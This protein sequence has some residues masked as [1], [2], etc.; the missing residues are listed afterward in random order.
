[1]PTPTGPG[2]R[3]LWSYPVSVD[4]RGLDGNGR[5][6]VVVDHYLFVG[7]AVLEPFGREVAKRRVTTA[8]VVKALDELEDLEPR[9]VAALEG[10][11]VKELGLERREEALGDRVVE[12]V[13]AAADRLQDP[14]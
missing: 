13:A 12:G 3:G 8:R 5:H 1:M 11:T 10:P 6:V 4:T 2:L 14:A 9:L 7:V